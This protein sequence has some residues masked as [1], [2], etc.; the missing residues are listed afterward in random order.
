ML[1][2]SED[3]RNIGLAIMLAAAA[4]SEQKPSITRRTSAPAS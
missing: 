2:G 4:I 3:M 1:S